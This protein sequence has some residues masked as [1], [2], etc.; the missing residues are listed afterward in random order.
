MCFSSRF[1]AHRRLHVPTAVTRRHCTLP[2]QYFWFHISFALNTDY[3]PK[4]HQR[5]FFLMTTHF[6]LYEVQT[7]GY[8]LDKIQSS[9]R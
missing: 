8:N 3:L 2:A 7:V 6:V 9:K 5:M 4:Q 1:K